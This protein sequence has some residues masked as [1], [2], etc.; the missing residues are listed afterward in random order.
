M[1]RPIEGDSFVPISQILAFRRTLKT[2]FALLSVLIFVALGLYQFRND[3]L[4]NKFNSTY[5]M[6]CTFF[7]HGLYWLI[8]RPLINKFAVENDRHGNPF[9]GWKLELYEDGLKFEM[10]AIIIGGKKAPVFF[11]SLKDISDFRIFASQQ[12]AEL[13]EKTSAGR[14]AVQTADRISDQINF[15]QG[16]IVRPEYIHD[17][18]REGQPSVLLQG[19]DFLYMMNICP[20]SKVSLFSAYEYWCQSIRK[21]S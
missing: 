16:K 3:I 4:L 14:L 9:A 17:S 21:S 5:A 6:W 20:S 12:E 13:F 7:G 1:F 11:I 15:L 8:A 10:K 19:L 2:S 18:P